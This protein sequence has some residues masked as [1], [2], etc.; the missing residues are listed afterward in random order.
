MTE[1]PRGKVPSGE[2]DSGKADN[3]TA[4]N[5]TARRIVTA[6]LPEPTFV[7]ESA[8]GGAPFDPDAWAKLGELVEAAKANGSHP[9]FDRLADSLPA[10][11]P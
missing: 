1:V 6:R 5:G 8:E 4:D 10:D 3:G 9:D 2:V 7:V 11:I